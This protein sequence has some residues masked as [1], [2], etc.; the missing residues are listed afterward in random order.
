MKNLLFF[1]LLLFLS[2]CTATLSKEPRAYSVFLDKSF[3]KNLDFKGRELIPIRIKNSW[4][5]VNSSGKA[6][7]VMLDEEG[8]VDSFKE[9]FAR[10]RI[11]G[12]I[13]FF[14]KNL[15]IVLEPIYDYAFPFYNGVAEICIGCKEFSSNGN[16]L[17]DGGVWKRIDR[18]GLIL[19][20]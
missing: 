16:S 15:D 17:L 8:R 1:I 20:E 4:Y 14:D 2:A 6:M 9:G 7:P 19:E 5:Y 3:V 10:T 18:R 13:G 11:N 12:K